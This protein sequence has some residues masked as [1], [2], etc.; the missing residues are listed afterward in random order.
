MNGKRWSIKASDCYNLFEKSTKSC[1][2]VDMGDG[3][4][5]LCPDQPTAQH[6]VSLHNK[7]WMQDKSHRGAKPGCIMWWIVTHW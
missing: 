4:M 7:A 6:I 5:I 3:R 1:Y 2:H